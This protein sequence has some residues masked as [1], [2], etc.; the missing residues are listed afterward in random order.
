MQ[1]WVCAAGGSTDLHLAA[2]P[3]VPWT[4]F[5]PA[6]H[7]LCGLRRIR[8]YPKAAAGSATCPPCVAIHA[9]RETRPRLAGWLPPGRE[10]VRR[11]LIRL[12]T[13]MWGRGPASYLFN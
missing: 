13:E 6:P 7:T 8:T 4:S 10:Q 3:T 11:D 5:G 12:H 2:T 1:Y 9:V